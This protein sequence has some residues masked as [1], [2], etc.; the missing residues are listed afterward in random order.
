MG[1]GMVAV[2]GWWRLGEVMLWIRVEG[3]EWY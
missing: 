2:E 3:A 1:R